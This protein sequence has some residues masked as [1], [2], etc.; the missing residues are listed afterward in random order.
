MITFQLKIIYA[1]NEVGLQESNIKR[2]FSLSTK[3]PEIVFFGGFTLQGKEK[4][5]D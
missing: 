1:V 3:S 4:E 5:L 2:F